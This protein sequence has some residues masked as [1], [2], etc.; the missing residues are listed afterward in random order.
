[1]DALVEITKAVYNSLVF[2]R[3]SRIGSYVDLLQ[4]L[5]QLSFVD[6]CKSFTE[7]KKFGCLCH[8]IFVALF[9]FNMKIDCP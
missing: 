2:N 4:I 9:N 6:S 5:V 3:I 8:R 7:G 1:M